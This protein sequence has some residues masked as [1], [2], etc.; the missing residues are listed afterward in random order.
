MSFR[1][2]GSKARVVDTIIDR[3]G[4]PDSGM[5]IDAFSGTGAVAE[6]ASRAGWKVHVNDHLS[7]SA[8]MSFARLVSKAD[9]L[10]SGLGGYASAVDVLNSLKPQRGFIWREYSHNIVLCPACI[11][12][13]AMPRRSV[14]SAARSANGA[15]VKT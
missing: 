15:L 9:V 14:Q 13:K 10:F 7:S 5:F 11:S 1:Y 3:I 6:A 2:I 12:R 8:I 4:S